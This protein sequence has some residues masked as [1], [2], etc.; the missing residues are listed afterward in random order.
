MQ[1]VLELD[2][3]LTRI[4]ADFETLV[5]ELEFKEICELSEQA[6]I[7]KL[8][9][10]GIYKIDIHTG[11]KHDSFASWYEWFHGQWV[12][13]E[14]KNKFVP[15]PKKKRIA[16]HMD[17]LRPEWAPLYL[18]KSRDITSRVSEHINLPLNKPTTA[19]KLGSRENMKNQRFRLSVLRIDVKNY[20]LIM[21]RI[22]SA[23]RDLHNPILGRQ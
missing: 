13:E 8:K 1:R 17:N 15:N 3:E 21:P 12:T 2:E 9:F 11:D 7:N 19:L 20:D 4:F 5:R 18:G 14:Y 6:K 22:E 10:P 23:L 16:I